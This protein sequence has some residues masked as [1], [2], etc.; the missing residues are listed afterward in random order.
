MTSATQLVDCLDSIQSQRSADLHFDVTIVFDP[1]IPLEACRSRFPEFHFVPNAGERTPLQLVSTALAQCKGD[2]ILLTK[3]HC[4][5]DRHWV[6]RMVDAQAPDRA[7]VGGRVEPPREASSVEWAFF[8]IDFYRYTSP[9]VEGW[10]PTLTVCNASYERSRLDAIRDL[11]Q[12]AFVETSVNDALA[13]RFG[14]L[15]LE[16]T[17]EVILHRKLTLSDAVFERYA[18]GRLFACSRLAGGS[19]R[20][21]LFYVAS[22]PALPLLLLGRLTNAALRSRRHTKALI[23]S[24]LPL[25]LMVLSR[26][27]GE[28]LGYVTARPPRS[29]TH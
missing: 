10:S 15:W 8:F 6:R 20:Q 29:F 4:V 5:P 3:D 12:N 28:W 2:L 26:S 7:A 1:E 22:S 18:F 9:V 16:E 21:R 11:W 19:M 23:R 25:A 17:S 14:R 24:F 13:A 27:V